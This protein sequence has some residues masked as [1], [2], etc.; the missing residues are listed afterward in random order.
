MVYSF[1]SLLVEWET[2]AFPVQFPFKAKD[3]KDRPQVQFN[4]NISL[5]DVA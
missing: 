2:A 3:T 5:A 1:P 4:E